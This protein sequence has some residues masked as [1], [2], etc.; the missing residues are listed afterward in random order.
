MR[1]FKFMWDA[2]KWTGIIA[3]LILLNLAVTGFLL[4]VKKDYGW[5]QPATQRGSEGTLDRF[6]TIEEL[7]ASVLA[8]NHP[9]FQS[10][11][12]I[13]RVDL[14]LSKRVHKVRSKRNYAEIQIDAVTGKVLSVDWR[15]SDLIE[16]LHDGSF[17]ADGVHD[18]VMP[19]VAVS[20]AFLFVSGLYLWLSPLL[21]KRRNKKR[22]LA[23]RAA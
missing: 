20:L 19:L 13:D 12:D 6:I 14:R 16:R 22:A 11:D 5:I 10:V 18:Y 2:H 9:D 3:G 23:K 8:A 1:L 21:R 17:F 4:L 15:P 7:V